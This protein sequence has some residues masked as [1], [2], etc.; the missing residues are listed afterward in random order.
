M[1][2]AVLILG[3]FVWLT[4]GAQP[5]DMGTSRF[6]PQ[7]SVRGYVDFQVAPPRNEIDL[8][9]CVLRTDNPF[10]PHPTCSAFAR[11]AW[12]GYV[13]LQPIGR[14][15]LRRL[16]LFAEPIV[17]GGDNL[18][19]RRYTVSGSPILSELSI[20]VGLELPNGFELRFK[21]HKAYML[22][23]YRTPEGAVDL[24]TDGPYGLYSTIGVRWKFGNWNR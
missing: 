14:G 3:V 6:F 20:G 1:R 21:N 9:L 5:A 2:R 19:Q 17:Y 13:E 8:G 22:G 15:P 16:F 12:G 18:P 23:K 11:Y 10:T 7:D 24:R 4:P